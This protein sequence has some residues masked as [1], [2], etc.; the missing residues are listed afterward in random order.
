MNLQE[1]WKMCK[2]CP[3][4]FFLWGPSAPFSKRPVCGDP[5]QAFG[6]HRKLQKTADFRFSQKTA[7]NRRLGSVTLGP[8][9]LVTSVRRPHSTY[10]TVVQG[11]CPLHCIHFNGVVLLEHSFPEHLCL[12]QFSV[13]QNNFYMQRFSNTSFGRTLLGSNF[14]G[15]LARTNFLSALCGLPTR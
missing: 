14:G 8:S 12:D 11:K 10:Q 1:P 6:G 4:L 9:P 13:I 5:I 2:A 3:N 15:P 7:G